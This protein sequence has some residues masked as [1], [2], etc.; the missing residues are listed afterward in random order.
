MSEMRK[1][2]EA[3]VVEATGAR[4]SGPAT[5]IDA[6]LAEMDEPDEVMLCAAELVAR[7]LVRETGVEPGSDLDFISKDEARDV[8]LRYWRAMLRAIR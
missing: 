1:R 6:I 2:L 8:A 4:F 7:A 3:L 5:T